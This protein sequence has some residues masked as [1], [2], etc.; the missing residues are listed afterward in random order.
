MSLSNSVNQTVSGSVFIDTLSFT[1]H[2]PDSMLFDDGFSEDDSDLAIGHINS[3]ISKLGFC[4]KVKN[5]YGKN[6]YKNSAFIEF[7]D[8]VREES[9]ATEAVIGFVA[10]G[11]NNNTFHVY[12]TGFACDYLNL[13]D[14]FPEVYK[15]LINSDS[16]I[17]RCDTAFDCVEGERTLDDVVSW[18]DGGRFSTKGNRP[19]KYSQ[20]GC[21]LGN[22]KHSRTF[23]VGSRESTKYFRAYEKGHQ[24]G[25][26]ESK[27][28]RF[29]MEFKA[30]NKAIIPMDILIKPDFYLRNSYD[31]LDFIPSNSSGDGIKYSIKKKIE[32]TIDQAICHAK[33]QYGK[34]VN[35]MVEMGFNHDDI[36]N[37]ISR[38]GVPARLIVP[39][40][41]VVK[42]DDNLPPF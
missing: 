33:K 38:E 2:F 14:M 6:F 35:V 39:P 29:E 12:L 34:L 1:T 5:N 17:N 27:W 4:V 30:K 15:I 32:V 20:L 23:Y 25:D 18:W 28:V 26:M 24:L 37:K 3:L 40:Y 16:K 42:Q 19:T 21:W 11:G 31:C 13:N 41:F 22:E 9:E 36:V 8:E 7:T 10:F